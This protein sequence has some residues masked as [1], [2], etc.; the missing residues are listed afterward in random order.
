MY[1]HRSFLLLGSDAGDLLSL[2]QNGY[3]IANYS[4]S[5]EQ[6]LD[7]KGKISTRVFGG[8]IHLTLP[9]LPLNALSN[10]V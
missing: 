3:E 4:F 1:G 6:G 8:A 7:D 9:Q 10:G 5:F 2:I